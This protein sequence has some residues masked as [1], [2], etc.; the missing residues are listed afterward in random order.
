MKPFCYAARYRFV[1]S[2]WVM[3]QTPGMLM[4]QYWMAIS[5]IYAFCLKM[6]IRISSAKKKSMQVGKIMKTVLTR[7][8]MLR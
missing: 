8:A 7:R 5:E 4:I 1:A 6:V 3:A 2:N